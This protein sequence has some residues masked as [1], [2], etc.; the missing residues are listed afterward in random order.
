MNLYLSL[1]DDLIQK[2]IKNQD[3]NNTSKKKN[4]GEKQI[5]RKNPL[6]FCLSI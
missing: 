4:S 6:S 1:P 5:R 3:L 2:L